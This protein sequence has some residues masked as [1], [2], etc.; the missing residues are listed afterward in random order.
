V[1]SS[2]SSRRLAANEGMKGFA[3]L[4]ISPKEMATT[5]KYF[6]SETPTN[7]KQN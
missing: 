7:Y 3:E 5:Q 4:E 6:L 2:Q 1:S